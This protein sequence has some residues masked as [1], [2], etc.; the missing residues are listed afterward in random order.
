M[1][2]KL[3][4]KFIDGLKPATT[5]R[6]EV[7]DVLLVGLLIRVSKRGA[8][9]W[10]AMPRVGNRN[11]RIKIGNY[12]VVTLADAREKARELLNAAQLG[13]FDELVVEQ[14][15][16]LGELIPQFIELY[17]KPRNR[18]W[19][20]TSRILTKFVS[21]NHRPINA[22]KRLEIVKVLDGLAAKTPYRANRALA[23][24]KKLFSW[25]VDRGTVDFSPVAGLKAPNKESARDRVL[26]SQELVACWQASDDEGFPFEQFAKLIILTGQRR[27]EVAGL[28]WSEIDF[29]HS[30]W[31]LPARSA[32]NK[33]QH[34][35]PLAPLAMD[36]LKSI[37]RFLNSD[38]VF[39]TNGYNPISGFG[40]LKD[41][42]DKAVGKSDWRIHDIRRTVA[43]NMAM[44]G[45][46]PHVIE[47]VLNHKSG[48]VSGVAAIYNRHAYHDE[49]RAALEKWADYVERLSIKTQD[50][51]SN[52]SGP[53][54][55]T[56]AHVRATRAQPMD[57]NLLA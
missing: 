23:A 10:Y 56:L 40:R 26:T 12:P 49:K 50:C 4:P 24:I 21:I 38:L 35:I 37:P 33:T 14:V 16:T 52:G 57:R 11:K 28:C 34:V 32:K 39:T 29:E 15:P 22:I 48:I 31:T 53:Q 6:Y 27:G 42:M 18:D 30:I 41:R 17:A 36:I 55:D 51:Q 2:E 43:T 45:V 54:A 19:L 13:K 47:A 8:K 20:E 44:M 3:T 7:R 9:I 46:Q 5:K 1:R 25:C